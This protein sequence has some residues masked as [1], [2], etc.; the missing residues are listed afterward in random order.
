M[1]AEASVPA[2]ALTDEQLASEGVLERF[3]R[4]GVWLLPVYGLANLIGTLSSQ[5]D[6]KK[7]F[8]AYARYIRTDEFLASHLLASIL[9]TG[10]GLLGF[11]ALF[12]YL[13][14]GRRPGVAASALVAT[15]VGMVYMVAMFGVAAFAQRA[16][17]K[18]YLAGHHDVV[19]LNSSVYG[20]AAN[21]NAGVSIGLLFIGMILFAIAISATRS[22][23]RA[24]GVL[25]A[26]WFPIFA[27]GSVTGDVLD[28]IGSIV[29]IAAGTWIALR[30]WR[31]DEV[32]EQGS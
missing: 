13:T 17:G 3:A 25:L 24:A 22:L 7:D 29:L 28:K 31:S 27:I 18:A 6:Y 23:P 12:V 5:P 15:V 2:V 11:V 30:V 21:V 8:P 16:I 26:V 32:V 9:G 19:Q 10:I 20:T 14:R 4:V 1:A